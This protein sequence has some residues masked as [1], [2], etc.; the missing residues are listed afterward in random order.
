[1]NTNKLL[2]AL[3]LVLIGIIAFIYPPTP[4]ASEATIEDEPISI[5]PPIVEAEV[6]IEESKPYDNLVRLYAEE[7]NVSYWL[8]DAIMTCENTERNAS[9]QSRIKYT[10]GIVDRNPQWGVVAGEYERS[11]GL[12]QIHLPS[13][14][15][16]TYEQAIDPD[17]S[18]RFLADHLSRGL[19]SRWSCYKK[20]I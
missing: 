7:Y 8:M 20:V 11:F 9:L 6:P 3:V 19:A 10:Q 15:S 5:E 4:V 13:N 2:I 12:V 16:V 1:M 17:F 14:P 18:I